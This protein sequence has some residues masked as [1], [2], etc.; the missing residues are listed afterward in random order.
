MLTTYLLLGLFILAGIIFMLRTYASADPAGLTR[1]VQRVAMISA[2][3]GALL[4]L[5]RVPLGSVFVGI[6]AI[7][8]LTLRWRALW[9]V[10]GASPNQPAGKTSRIDTK[11]LRMALDH[12]TGA[13]DGLVLSGK[14]RDTLL[15]KLTLE[16]LLE[17]RADCLVDDPEGV[18]LIEAYLDRIH[19]ASWRGATSGQQ[20]SEDAAPKP[21]S[22]TMTREEALQVLGL[23][24]GATD[25]EIREAY[26]KLIRKLHPDHGG[27]D[28]LA[29]KL[30][31]ARDVL[32]G[33]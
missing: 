18:P 27:S 31:Q 1:A 4:L 17:V 28:Y 5:L 9:P 29:A 13:F 30:N 23:A 26:H 8:P 20:S 11:H 3:L 10:F 21:G 19:G 14:H 12:D 24:P 7:L 22:T 6:G 2:A 15:S 32:I 16:Q 25:A 33:S